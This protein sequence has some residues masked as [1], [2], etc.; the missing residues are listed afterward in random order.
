M[1]QLLLV[2][3]FDQPHGGG[4]ALGAAGDPVAAERAIDFAGIEMPRRAVDCEG[5]AE[6]LHERRDRHVRVHGRD[7]DGAYARAGTRWGLAGAA[8][9]LDQEPRD[10]PQH[11]RVAMDETKERIG[12]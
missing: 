3:P 9:T 5:V 2:Q 11:A 10:P 1:P 7:R 6:P 12:R 4:V 8:Q